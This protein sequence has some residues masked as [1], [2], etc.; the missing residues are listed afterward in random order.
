M[1]NSKLLVKI[2]SVPGALRR[3]FVAR[4]Q[5]ILVTW[6]HANIG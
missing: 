6:N 3:R 4:T 2:W 5:K 1:R